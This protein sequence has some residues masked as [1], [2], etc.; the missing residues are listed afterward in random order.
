MACE[1]H[2]EPQQAAMD[3]DGE[4]AEQGVAQRMLPKHCAIVNIH[5]QAEEKR[6]ANAHA[7]RLMNVPKNQHQGH[8]VRHGRRTAQRHD[9]E[10][11]CTEQ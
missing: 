10:R 9:V 7:A 1:G 8:E 4:K 11:K 5:Q 3:G 6:Q 2:R